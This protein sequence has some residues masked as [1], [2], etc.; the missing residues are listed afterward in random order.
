MTSKPPNS[1]PLGEF[2]LIARYL[3]PLATSKAARGLRDDVAVLGLAG[4]GGDLVLNVDAIVAGVH[5]FTDD[6]PNVIAERV[7][8]VN[9][10]DL[11]A[12]GA[13]PLGYL[14]TLALST[15]QDEAWIADFTEGLRRNQD[16]MGWSLLGG[17]TVRT[18]GLLTISVTA[19]GQVETGT[20]PMRGGAQPGDHIWVSG[21]IGDAALGLAVCQGK[22]P[23]LPTSLDDF[24]VERFR[25]PEPRL[26]LGQA[27]VGT[28][29]V[30]AS[31]DVSDGLIADLGHIAK[32][33]GL[34]ARIDGTLVPTS[35][36]GGTAIAADPVWFERMITGGDD[37]ELLLTTPPS[38]A[39]QFEQIASD[40]GISLTK[41]GLMEQ[42]AG[43]FV[44]NRQGNP[45]ALE[46]AGYRHF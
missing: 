46:T 34:C 12:K 14:L 24:V 20:V 23:G 42:G 45:L 21:T 44:T 11:A 38:A 31:A 36:A 35:L 2:D 43:V 27:L 37:Y 33:S 28:G 1:Q 8:R 29:M 15:D 7:L 10:S 30:S 18:S 22:G 25:Q 16:T 3:A 19:I 13:E 40:C 6:P 17:D 32:A 26:K 5:F 4:L 39:S 9:L 41:I